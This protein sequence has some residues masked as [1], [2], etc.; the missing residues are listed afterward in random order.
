[1]RKTKRMDIRGPRLKKP[2]DEA[3]GF[4][5]SMAQDGRI[6]RHIVAVNMAHMLELVASGEV[7][8]S[9]GGSC[10]KFL[11]NASTS[12]SP[13]SKAEDF[14]QQLEQDAVDALGVDKAGYLNF[15]KSRNDQVATA[16]RMELRVR[17]V[18]LLTAVSGLQAS[19]LNFATK[20]SSDIMPGYTHLQ[21]AQPVT[22]GHHMFAHFDSLQRDTERLIQLYARVNLSPMGS[23]AMA[24]TSAK[25]DRRAVAASLGFDGIVSNAMDG[26][27]SR[28]FA[29]EALSIASMVTLN[30]GRLAEELILWSSAEFGFVEMDD[31][32][33]ASSSIMPQKKNAVV[34][35]IVRAK[36]GSVIGSLVSVFSIMKALPY[37]YNLDLQEATPHL[38]R[39]LDDSTDSA[40]LM[41]GVLRTLRFNSKAAKDAV[42]SDTSTAVGLANYLVREHG[43]SFR[44]AHSMVGRA[45][46]SA[47]EKHQSLQA[48]VETGGLATLN[49]KKIH[50]DGT[51]LTRLL[52]PKSFLESIATEGGSNPKFIPGEMAKRRKQLASNRAEASRL[53]EALN[54]TERKLRA[55]ASGIAREVNSRE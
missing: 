10:L 11:L 26:V 29:L 9:V 51:T 54:E 27:A 6:A 44:E 17:I 41:S 3:L 12:I 50:I 47:A 24:G 31:A 1:M 14:H 40:R 33:A 39:A 2:S 35:E 18:A 13:E 16:I 8:K 21:R 7:D 38:W 42:N 25:I 20:H 34:A 52:E 19:I 46:K 45:V 53:E 37:S 49:G 15:G 28:D 43:L 23:A 55:K 32:F 48:A 22:V 5:S 4:T 36:E 30:T